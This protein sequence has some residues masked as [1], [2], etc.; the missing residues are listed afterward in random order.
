MCW[1]KSLGS[2]LRHFRFELVIVRSW[3]GHIRLAEVLTALI[4]GITMTIKELVATNAQAQLLMT[5]PGISYYS[6][7]LRF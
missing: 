6:A 5:V 2:G 4:Q 7:I 1:G 3:Y